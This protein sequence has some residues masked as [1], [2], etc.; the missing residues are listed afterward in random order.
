MFSLWLSEL[1]GRD[2]VKICKLTRCYG[3]CDCTGIPPDQQRLI[4]AGKQL[5]DGRT[6]ADY[7]IQKGLLLSL[8]R[9]L[10]LALCW[11]F[12][13]NWIYL[14]FFSL[15]LFRI[16]VASGAEASWRDHRAF[17]DGFGPQIQSRQDDLPQVRMLSVWFIWYYCVYSWVTFWIS[18]NFLFWMFQCLFICWWYFF[19]LWVSWLMVKCRII[20]VSQSTCVLLGYI[21]FMPWYCENFNQWILFVYIAYI[22]HLALIWMEGLLGVQISGTD[23]FLL[24]VLLFGSMG[25]I[26]SLA[27][28]TNT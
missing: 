22:G 24:Y 18:L 21:M 17:F 20:I 28:G 2:F 27:D 6:L 5:E 3:V 13:F 8:A 11:N 10:S 19:P 9:A 1:S 12:I 7:N 25:Y 15:V 23:D 26:C 14:F 16:D 4:F